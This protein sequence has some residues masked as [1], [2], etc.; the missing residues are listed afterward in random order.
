MEQF[1]SNRRKHAADFDWQSPK[2]PLKLRLYSQFGFGHERF[3]ASALFK[4]LR[5]I[6]VEAVKEAVGELGR[7]S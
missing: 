7:R 2:L 1:A 3:E 6:C 4:W 5:S